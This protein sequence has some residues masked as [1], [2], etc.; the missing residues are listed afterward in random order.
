MPAGNFFTGKCSSTAD[1]K[2]A[3]TWVFIIYL[4]VAVAAT[5]LMAFVPEPE[6]P[7]SEESA[8]DTDSESAIPAHLRPH[9]EVKPWYHKVAAATALFGTN[10]RAFGLMW[11]TVAFSF[12]GT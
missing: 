6:E 3:I 12:C 10:P 11:M 9:V 1:S 2:K 7:E 4:I 8:S 5:I